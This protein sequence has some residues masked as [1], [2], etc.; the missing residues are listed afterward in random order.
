[1]FEPTPILAKIRGGAS[2]D[3]LESA[4]LDFKTEKTS[5]FK[6][7]AIDLA[8]ACVCFANASGGTIVVGVRDKPGGPEAFAGSML[9]AEKL[10]SAI[11]DRTEPHMTVTVDVFIFDD[12]RLLL[13]TVPEGLEVYS[14]SQGEYRQRWM[15][16]C[17]PMDPAAVARLSDERRGNDW[18]SEPSDSAI[19]DIDPGALEKVRDLLR[20]TDDEPRVRL[21]RAPSTEIVRRLGLVADNGNL[22]RAGAILLVENAS[23]AP[24][25]LLVYQHRRTQSGEADFSRRWSSPLIIAFAD[26][27]EVVSARLSI[28]PITVRSGQQLTIEDFSSIAIREALANALIHRDLR[29]NQP[30]QIRHSPSMLAI[31]SPGPLVA[32]VTP[33]NILTRGTK[34]RYPSLAKAFNTLGW[35]EYLGQGVNRMFREM[36]RSGRP[37]PEINSSPDR[38]EVLFRGAPPNIHVARLVAELPDELKNDTDTLLILMQLCAKKS[39]TAQQIA[40]IIQRSIGDAESALRH[41]SQ[42]DVELLEPTVGTRSRRFPN[43]R[44]RGDVLARLGPAVAYH[45]R[46]SREVDRKIIDHVREYNSINNATIQRLFDID[47]YGA[48]DILKDLVGREVLTRISTQTRGKAVKYGPGPK[49][50]TKTQRLR[51]SSRNDPPTLFD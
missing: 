18:S 12:T 46:T 49:F 44:F 47:V 32:G 50:P 39:V 15:S 6:E 21:S 33:E 9:D 29:E 27:L 42:P 23:C 20:L 34:P 11:Y 28:T 13:I 14:T 16:E 41:A 3:S 22:T 31:D 48:R 17:R 4:T 36:A 30:V 5:G 26:A 35:G 40:P 1:M 38:V 8:E 24:Q 45:S 37:L 43:Y 19:D 10:R 2:G 25:E 51:Q 7:T